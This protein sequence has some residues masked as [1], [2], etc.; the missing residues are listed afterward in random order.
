MR[1]V[2]AL[3]IPLVIMGGIIFGVTTPTEAAAVAVLCA[4]LA[5]IVYRSMSVSALYE[6]LKRTASLSGSIFILLA[7][8]AIFSYLAG[9]EQIPLAL[10]KLLDSLGSTAGNTSCS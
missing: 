9:I 3:V 4:I 8:V 2:P 1:A 10:A 7:A 5:G 6:A